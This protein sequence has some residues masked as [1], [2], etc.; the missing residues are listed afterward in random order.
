MKRFTL[1]VIALFAIVL[2]A[3]ASAQGHTVYRPEL[4]TYIFVPAEAKAVAAPA[5]ETPA[6]VIA[7]HTAMAIGYRANANDRGIAIAAAHCDRMVAEAREA[8]RKNQ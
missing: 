5:A 3:A 2:P 1:A 8:L 7:R 4:R 6:D